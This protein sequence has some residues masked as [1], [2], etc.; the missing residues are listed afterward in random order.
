MKLIKLLF[1][2][3]F[4][5]LNSTLSLFSQAYGNGS[6][7]I[8]N[9]SGSN[10]NV[11]SYYSVNSITSN[12]VIFNSS[13]PSINNM[14]VLII[15]MEGTLAGTWEWGRIDVSN[16]TTAQ[17]VAAITKTYNFSDKVQLITVP[18]YEYLNINPGAS[19][20]CLPYNP[21]TG[22]GGVLAFNVKETFSIFQGGSC[23]VTGK[24]YP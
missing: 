20:T 17:L 3:L 2:V 14:R 12:F 19:L 7:G 4:I 11:N 13:V 16:G 15:Q 10:Q 5:T 8:V 6:L 24:G 21:T 18:E 22:T 23:N 1:L 9:V